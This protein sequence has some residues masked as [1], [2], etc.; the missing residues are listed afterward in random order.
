MGDSVQYIYAEPN[1]IQINPAVC[2]CKSRGVLLNAPRDRRV[3]QV[4]ILTPQ[5]VSGSALIGFEDKPCLP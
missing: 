2:I 1:G 4:E 5:R 3:A